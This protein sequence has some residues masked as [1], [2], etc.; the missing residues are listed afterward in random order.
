LPDVDPEP[1]HHPGGESKLRE[2]SASYG[3]ILYRITRSLGTDLVYQQVFDPVGGREPVTAV[4]SD[5]LSGIY[6]DLAGGLRAVREHPE[7][8]PPSVVW[9]RKFDLQSHWGRHATSAIYAMHCF[10]S[11]A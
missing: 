10:L 11:D 7:A 9:Q 5:D 8:V 3:E 6:C 4:F 2:H 1:E